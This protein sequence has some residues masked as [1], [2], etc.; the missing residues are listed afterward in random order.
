MHFLNVMEC[1]WHNPDLNNIQV[2]KDIRRL[3]AISCQKIFFPRR[4]K[5]GFYHYGVFEPE[6]RGHTFE[7]LIW[8]LQWRAM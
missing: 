8:T 5:R 6:T 2:G 1:Y 7:M 4:L 3:L